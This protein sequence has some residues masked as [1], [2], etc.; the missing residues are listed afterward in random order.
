V[1]RLENM[2]D[3]EFPHVVIVKLA[4]YMYSIVVPYLFPTEEVVSFNDELY[5]KGTVVLLSTP[6]TV[7]CLPV[8]FP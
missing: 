1:R 7:F 4:D 2:L 6:F 5:R 3:M 8:S